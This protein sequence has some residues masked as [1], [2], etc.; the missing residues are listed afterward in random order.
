MPWKVAMDKGWP[1]LLSD[2]DALPWSAQLVS[3]HD[4]GQDAADAFDQLKRVLARAIE[5]T[6][7]DVKH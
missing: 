1:V 7:S 6:D 2:K 5:S 3:E 4:N